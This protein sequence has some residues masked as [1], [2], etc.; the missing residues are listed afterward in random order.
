MRPLANILLI[1]SVLMSSKVWAEPVSEFD[2]K[3][4]F[5]YN[6]MLYTSWPK[7]SI[8]ESAPEVTVCTIGHEQ[9]GSALDQLKNK[10]VRNK[11]VVLNRLID[12]KDVANCHLLYLAPSEQANY[13]TIYE[14][15]KDMQVLTVSDFSRSFPPRAAISIEIE[16]K[17]LTFKVDMHTVNQ[18]GLVVSSRLLNLAKEV[19]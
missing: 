11:A 18:S 6:F 7:G 10:K 12:I 1:I 8:Q 3:T 15:I 14:Q 13:L 2:L 17:R 5:L 19:Y 9:L 4:A 16:D